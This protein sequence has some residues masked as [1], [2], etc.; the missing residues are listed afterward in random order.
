M[1]AGHGQRVEC[2]VCGGLPL[3]WIVKLMVFGWW[4]R[5]V[6]GVVGDLEVVCVALD[7][8]PSARR[9]Y[10]CTPAG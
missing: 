4:F 9:A 6:V 2:S 7:L 5:C 3:S 8:N 1:I 10:D